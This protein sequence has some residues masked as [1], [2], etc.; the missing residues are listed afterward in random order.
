MLWKLKNKTG[1]V[2]FNGWLNTASRFWDFKVRGGLKKPVVLGMNSIL[3]RLLLFNLCNFSPTQNYK[4]VT[5]FQLTI[6]LK[7]T[8]LSNI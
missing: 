6:Q 2:I 1:V 3:S 7:E 4:I 8:K 5:Q